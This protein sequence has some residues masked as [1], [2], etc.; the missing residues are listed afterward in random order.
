[1][2]R[3]FSILL[4]LFNALFP[5]AVCF[6]APGDPMTRGASMGILFLLGVILFVLSLIGSFIFYLYYKTRSLDKQKG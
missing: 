4:V 3:Y 6:G 2:M 1:M 5:C